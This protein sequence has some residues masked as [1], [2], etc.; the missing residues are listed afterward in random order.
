MLYQLALASLV[1]GALAV[2][3]TVSNPRY[4]YIVVGGGTSGL[5]VA[6]RLSE[7][8]TVSV[9]IIEAGD[10]VMNNT[11]VTDIMGYS[12]AFGTAID[13][14][15]ESTPQKYAGGKAQVMR[16][17]KAIGGTSTINGMT[18]LRAETAQIDA[19]EKLG[20][21]GWNW[22]TLLEYYKKS[23]YFQT[24]SAA[25]RVA[26]ASGDP[27]V[28]G[29]TGPLTVG[30]AETMMNGSI[31]HE[32]N[33]TYQALGLDYNPEPNNGTLRGINIFPKTL[34]NEQNVREDAGRAYYYPVSKRPNLDIYLNAFAERMTWEAESHTE[35]PFAN[36]VTFT[37]GGQ[38]K[39]IL[40]NRE[41][42]LSAGALRSPLILEQSGVGN[43]AI[44]KK[45]GVPV[46]VANRFVGENLQDQTTS[47]MAFGSK[48]N[49]TGN[50]GFAGYFTAA[51]LFGNNS[52][53]IEASVVNNIN[54]YAARVA[55]ATGNV[56]DVNVTA[57]LFKIQSDL[58]FQNH[59]PV[60]EI[61]VTPTSTGTFSIEYWGLLPFS[62][63]NI[64]I[65]SSNASAGAAI[66]PNYFM[67][68]YDTAQQVYS[69][70]MA[71][72][73]ANTAPLSNNINGESEPGLDVVGENA[74]DADWAKWVKSAYRS[75][76][77]YISTAAM[78]SEELGGV[79][80]D[81]LLVY[82]T[83]NVRVVDASVIPMQ[84]CG[85]LTSTLYAV[86]EKAADAIKG[87]YA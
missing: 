27:R 7:D 16:A 5:V 67:L 66:D 72:T 10:S 40:A 18:Y 51:Q 60:S 19:W 28:H 75:N 55:N 77:H 57:S 22:T 13:W 29:F 4:D 33:S 68:E 9:A 2:P 71:R 39:T 35:K 41:I 30:W 76:F 82:G 79:V 24:P 42:I 43:P 85:H 11:N 45:A 6:N 1:S 15:Y 78:M 37:T 23:E 52:A 59:L 62:R 20:N 53:A 31:V 80:D 14:A 86:A 36:G 8:P 44:L 38:Q 46:K 63:G 50:A 87:R 70:K 12:K 74:S 64:H 48:S 81:S 47:D 49:Y 21:H 25:Q 73:L 84:V 83:D 61:L 32:I 3:A 69:S 34:D 26:G 58:I 54:S 17:A 56:I 65:T